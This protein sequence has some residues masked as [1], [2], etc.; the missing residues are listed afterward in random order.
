M[1]VFVRHVCVVQF[2]AFNVP[3]NCDLRAQMKTN[4]IG[5]ACSA[6]WGGKVRRRFWWGKLREGDHLEDVGVGERII[7]KWIFKT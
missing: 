1:F 4:E 6:R 2:N 5:G 7:L 3:P